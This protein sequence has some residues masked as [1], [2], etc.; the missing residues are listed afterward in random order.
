MDLDTEGR[1]LGGGASRDSWDDIFCSDGCV[2][3][4]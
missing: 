4:S 3:Q 1:T 2:C